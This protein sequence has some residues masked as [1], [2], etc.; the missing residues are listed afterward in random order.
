MFQLFL[1]LLP[2]GK[3][4]P[5]AILRAIARKWALQRVSA[6]AMADTSELCVSMSER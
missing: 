2:G 4:G 6:K 5:D 3:P 1:A